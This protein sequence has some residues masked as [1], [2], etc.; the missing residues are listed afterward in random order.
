MWKIKET[1]QDWKTILRARVVICLGTL[2]VL[3]GMEW[4]Q[5]GAHI[6]H[7]EGNIDLDIQVWNHEELGAHHLITIVVEKRGDG[8]KRVS[9][10]PRKDE[11]IELAPKIFWDQVLAWAGACESDR[12]WWVEKLTLGCPE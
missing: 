10:Y 8:R 12:P 4:V 6:Y 2:E 1:T 9:F 11:G 5:R 7:R 3:Q